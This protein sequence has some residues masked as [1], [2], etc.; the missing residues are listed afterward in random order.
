MN[1]IDEALAQGASY[2]DLRHDI[3][4]VYTIIRENRRTTSN[5]L[6]INAGFCLR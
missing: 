1:I 2:A 3:K 6:Q 4:R 5:E